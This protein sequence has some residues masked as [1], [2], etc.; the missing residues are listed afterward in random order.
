MLCTIVSFRALSHRF[1][2][3]RL[4]LYTPPYVHATLCAFVPIAHH[5]LDG[6]ASQQFPAMRK[7]LAVSNQWSLHNDV[8]RSSLEA[9]TLIMVELAMNNSRN[10][11]I[12]EAS[13]FLNNGKH[14]VYCKVPVIIARPLK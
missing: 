1:V 4:V 12:G 14:P 2:I 13:F 11:S 7:H 5:T 3:S 10:A 9:T 6:V 8:R